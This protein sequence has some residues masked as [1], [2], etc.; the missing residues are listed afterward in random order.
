MK[1]TPAIRKF[2]LTAHVTSAV[3]WLGAVASFLAL[4]VSAGSG[5]DPQLLRG[6]YLAMFVTGWYIV[7]PL[8]LASLLTGLVMSLGTKW[9]LFRHYWVTVKFL[10]TIISTLVLFG[11]TQTLNYMG[12]AAADTSAPIV[13]L[14]NLA[15]SPVSHSAGGLI[16]LL[17]NSVLSIYKPLGR[18]GYA[19]GDAEMSSQNSLARKWE[20]YLLLGFI[21][22]VV[23][24]LAAHLL[25]R[26]GH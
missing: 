25:S 1:M 6:L 20:R 2:A 5:Y 17:M 3:G 11:F 9:G 8:C 12:A 23:L 10:L 13:E 15:Q 4:A 21:V 14:S 16:V 7:V 22:F 19:S 26:E 18:I 24:F